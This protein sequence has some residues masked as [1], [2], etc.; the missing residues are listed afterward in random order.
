MQFIVTRRTNTA[1]LAHRLHRHRRHDIVKVVALSLQ[2]IELCISRVPCDRL[3]N[4]PAT[5]W[6]YRAR[7]TDS[8]RSTRASDRPRRPTLPTPAVGDAPAP[9]GAAFEA[10]VV[11]PPVWQDYSRSAIRYCSASVPV[12]PCTTP[13]WRDAPR[14]AISTSCTSS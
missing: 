11:W 1:R 10:R 2:R 9:V 5:A 6:P 14:V 4:Q 13:R 3:T 8:T 12:H 7:S